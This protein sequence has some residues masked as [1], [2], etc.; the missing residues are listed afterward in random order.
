MRKVTSSEMKAIDELC[1]KA[2][3]I[4]GIV[5]ME[6]AALKVIKHIDSKYNNFT[7]VCGVGNNGGDG[8][9]VARHLI[10]EDKNVDIFVL[11]NLDKASKDFTT[12]Y[13]ILI[14]LG[15]EIQQ[16]TREEDLKRISKSL[17]NSQMTIDSIFGTGLT[18]NVEG[19]FAKT[20]EIMN[21]KSKYII[22]VDIPSGLNADNGE[23][24]N[25]CIKANKT[26][27]LQLPKIG[28]STFNGKLNSGEVIVETI[29]MPKIAIEK[30][31]G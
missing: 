13:N 9:A 21:E 12:N 7:I 14:N 28:L 30:I 6:N 19:L 5:L 24:L 16:I 31:L 10:V 29:G 18:R 20:I 3:G 23:I 4:P 26:I 8:L 22:S 25:K 1:I 11:G 17:D 27:T 15:V 2:I